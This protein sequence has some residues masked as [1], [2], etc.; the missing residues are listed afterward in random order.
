MRK[1]LPDWVSKLHA[2]HPRST[3]GFWLYGE[4]AAAFVPAIIVLYL[5]YLLSGVSQ[6]RDYLRLWQ[7]GDAETTSSSAFFYVLS[8]ITFFMIC[9]RLRQVRF[10]YADRQPVENVLLLAVFITFIA[11]VVFVITHMPGGFS[12]SRAT[13]FYALAAST[14]ILSTFLTFRA[15]PVEINAGGDWSNVIGVYLLALVPLIYVVGKLVIYTE[16]EAAHYGVIT[17]AL[18]ALWGC[19]FVLSLL[20]SLRSWGVIIS[21]ALASAVVSIGEFGVRDVR[22][23]DAPVERSAPG[24]SSDDPIIVVASD[25]GGIRSA[26]WTVSVLG[27]M[28]AVRPDLADKIYAMGGASGGS[29]GVGLVA[30][31]LADGVPPEEIKEKAQRVLSEDYLATAVGH[32]IFRDFFCSV[33]VRIT[34]SGCERDRSSMLEI[35]MERVYRE[36]LKIDGESALE[37]VPPTKPILF[38]NTTEVGTNRSVI[39]GYDVLNLIESR[40]FQLVEPRRLR[41]S[42]AMFLS[43]RFPVIGID[44]R[45]PAQISPTGRAMELIDG[46]YADNTG[47]LA[48]GELIRQLPEAARSRVIALSLTNAPLRWQIDPSISPP[49]CS[50]KEA[51]KAGFGR[52]LSSMIRTLD[53]VRAGASEEIRQDFKRGVEENSGAWF[54]QLSYRECEGDDTGVPLGWTLSPTAREQLDLQAEELAGEASVLVRFLSEAVPK[55]N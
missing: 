42:T 26:Y 40:D 50:Q 27:G 44:G 30:G 43:A 29:V 22:S 7:P 11:I 28:L 4:I 31:M 37:S 55:R 18:L 38:L 17:M 19:V 12:L 16:T 46:G 8:A 15:P 34:S 54:H 2:H 39:F 23:L 35:H 36:A 21:I 53:G 5:L 41:L 10:R 13:G 25:G 33:I 47:T 49:D 1:L 14:L 24:V 32:M 20:F 51:P 3:P 6:I 52:I 9:R 45:L 48:L